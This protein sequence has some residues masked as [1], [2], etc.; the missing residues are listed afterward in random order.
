VFVHLDKAIHGVK[1]NKVTTLEEIRGLLWTDCMTPIGAMKRQYEEILD[2][3]KLQAAVEEQLA[4]YNLLTDKPM[5]LVLFS[6]AVEHLLIIGRILKQPSGNALLVGVGGSGRQSLTKLATKISDY[7]PFQIEI[8]K[9][10]GK[11][12]WREDLKKILKQSGARNTPTVFLFTDSQI[13]DE[14]FVEDINNLLNTYEVPNLFPSDEKAEMLEIVRP[15]AKAE[16]KAPD[17]TPTQLYSFFVEKCKKNLHVVLGFSPIGDAFRTRVRMFPSLVNCCTI[18]WF[19]EW[20]QDALLWVARRFLNAVDM[21][22]DV[23]EK[24]VEMVQFFHESTSHWAKE[25]FK[26]LKRKYYVTPTSYIELITTFKNLLAEKRLEVQTNI[27]KYENGYEKIIT[28]EKS[29]EGMQKNL[30]ELQPKL[31]EAAANTEVKMKEV[32]VEKA[33]ADVLKENIQKEEAIVQVAVNEANAIKEECEKD[34][35]EAL[36]A[37]KSAEDALKVLDKKKL[38]LLKTMKS[39]PQIIKVVMRALCIVKYPKPTETFKNPETLKIEV[40]WWAA[41]MKLLG[42]VKLLDELLEFDIENADEQII[43]NL[44]KYLK[45][46]ANMPMLELDA[47]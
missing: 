34:L 24:C 29:V 8:T 38:D 28:T 33:S 14:S 4:N 5:D 47:V 36:P 16:N 25:F 35:A 31:K 27:N 13:K 20:P 37:L 18:D 12:E 41:S 30:I 3:N 39:P 43:L 9:T 32:A 22:N 11:V 46:P 45:D 1:D 17:G 21:E 23:R 7:E 26:K 44:G 19:Q 15:V 6:F 40:D 2:P 10:Y 42:N